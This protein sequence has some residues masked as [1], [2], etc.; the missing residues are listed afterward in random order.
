MKQREETYHKLENSIHSTSSEIASC[1]QK[2]EALAMK[3]ADMERLID[4]ERRRW[5]DRLEAEKKAL[6][7]K[8]F[9]PSAGSQLALSTSSS[10]LSE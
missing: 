3:I 10:R 4:E 8:V 9:G 2:N 5:R 7:M 6:Q 1:Q